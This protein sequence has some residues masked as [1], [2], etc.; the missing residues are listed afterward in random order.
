MSECDNTTATCQGR[1]RHD[2]EEH[3]TRQLLHL[4]L[5]LTLTLTLSLTLTLTLTLTHLPWEAAP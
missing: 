4:N 1:P 5:T 3:G 2:S